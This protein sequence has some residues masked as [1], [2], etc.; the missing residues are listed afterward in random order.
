MKRAEARRAGSLGGAGTYGRELAESAE[1][2]FP[3]DGGLAEGLV[4]ED[5]LLHLI[6][7]ALCF[8]WLHLRPDLLLGQLESFLL[9]GGGERRVRDQQY[10]GVALAPATHSLCCSALSCLAHF[11]RSSACLSRRPSSFS[12]TWWQGHTVCVGV[13]VSVCVCVCIEGG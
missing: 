1:A 9:W 4:P 7:L 6:P 10:G 13:C 3:G 8:S 11:S 2:L 12:L 5:E